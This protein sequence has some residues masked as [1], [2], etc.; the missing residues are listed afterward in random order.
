MRKLPPLKSLQAFE[1]TA[2]HLSFS[3]ASEELFVTPAAVSQQVRQLEDWLQVQ[4]FRRLTREIRLT[5]AGQKALPLMTEGFDR[6]AEGVQRLTEDDEI[7]ILT[8]TTAPTF[9]AKWLV[10]RLAHFNELYPE[11]NV[12]IDASLSLVDFEREGVHIGIRLG[13]G[14]YPSMRSDWFMDEDVILAFSPLLMEGPHP[15][16]TPEALKHHRLLHVDW[17]GIRNPPSFDQWLKLAG[18]EGVDVRRGDSFTVENLAIQ[19][20]ISGGGV[21]LVSKLSVEEDLGAG[22]LIAP[23]DISLATEAYWIVTPERLAERP[24]IV[25]FRNWLFEEA[26]QKTGAAAFSSNAPDAKNARALSLKDGP[27]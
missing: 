11:L 15:L 21:V 4:L 26:G 10:P 13:A 5:D 17:G 9:A 23:F 14:E 27:R 19:V 2:R 8:V 12:R 22:R 6:M 24:K 20:A 7:G 3:K 1:A 18:V 25:A 16:A